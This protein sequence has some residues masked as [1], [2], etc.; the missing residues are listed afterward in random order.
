[1]PRRAVPD[2]RRGVEAR[3]GRAWV[4]LWTARPSPEHHDPTMN[5]VGGHPGVRAHR[6]SSD[7][8]GFPRVT[9]PGPFVI[10]QLLVRVET[11][12]EQDPACGR[13][14]RHRGTTPRYRRRAG[15]RDR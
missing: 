6:R 12:D 15:G 3:A 4:V 9:I 5:E 8:D 14:V 10:E 2:P 1:R 7:R 13:V 11:T